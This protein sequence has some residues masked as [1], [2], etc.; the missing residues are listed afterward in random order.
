MNNCI[1]IFVISIFLLGCVGSSKEDIY[2][3]SK[4]ELRENIH[5]LEDAEL[6]LKKHYKNRN[7]DYN[8]DSLKVWRFQSPQFAQQTQS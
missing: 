6:F 5:A 8:V 2:I 1:V 3:R 7:T 4:K